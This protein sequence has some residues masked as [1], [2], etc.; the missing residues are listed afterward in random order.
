M[1]PEISP[2]TLFGPY[3]I[4][5]VLGVGGMGKVYRARDTRLHRTVAIKVLPHAKVA[6]DE[7]KR[8]F[9]QEA[10]AVS[11][12]NH[13]N[14]VTLH[15]MASEGGVDYLVMEYVPGSS[16]DRLITPKGLP[17]DQAVGY[18][19]QI[20]NAL[21]A[22]H[23]AGIVHRDMKPA[24]V[25]VTP[26]QAGGADHRYATESQVKV[27]DFGLAKL[28]G[29]A[30]G[31]EDETLT[32]ESEFTEAGK[33]MGTVAYMSPEQAR[34][35]QVDHRTDIFSLAVILY[36]MVAGTRPFRGESPVETMHGIINDPAPPL[37][38]QPPELDEILAKAMGKDPRHRYCHA[39]DFELDLRRF[40]SAWTLKELPSQRA[41]IPAAQ[42]STGRRLVV[43]AAVTL[44]AAAAGAAFSWWIKPD[45]P[46]RGPVLTSLP[47]D[48][49]LTTDPILSS[50]GRFVAYASD[51][52]GDGNLDIW[53]QQVAG[54]EPVRLTRDPADE[55]EPSFSPDGSKIAFRSERDGGGIYVISTLGGEPRRI[56]DGGRR[57]R[58]SPDGRQIA[59]WTGKN[60]NFQIFTP[61]S[62]KI[63]V[64]GSGGGDSREIQPG[65]LLARSPVWSA[66]GKYLLFLG[67]RDSKTLEVDWW[68][69]P[70]DSGQAVQT[71]AHALLTAYGLAPPDVFFIP[72]AWTKHGNGVLFAGA[73]GDSTN[74]WRIAIPPGGRAT[75]LP[76]RLTFGAGLESNPS[77]AA[78]GRLV[79]STLSNNIDLW[80]LPTDTFH[81][82]QTGSP[83]ERLTHDPAVDYYPA[84]SSDGKKLIY[85]STQSENTSLWLLDM[86]A[87]K[88]TVI[89]P[90]VGRWQN[91]V[92]TRDG[93]SI[94]FGELY[95]N[96][97]ANPWY[98]LLL[99]NGWAA[100]PGARQRL[101]DNCWPVWDLSADGRWLLHSQQGDKLIV[102]R[103]MASGRTTELLRGGERMTA[104]ARISP[105]NRWVIFDSSVRQLDDVFLIPFHPGMPPVETPWIALTAGEGQNAFPQWSLDSRLVYYFSDRDGRFCVWAQRIRPDTGH[106]DGEPFPVWHFHDARR[107]L[108]G[109]PYELMGMAIAPGRIVLS[110][111]EMSGNIW[112][113]QSG[114]K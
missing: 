55:S 24:N 36:E 44:C 71:G 104:K 42:P 15:D 77:V 31:P 51:R 64:I 90:R 8:R 19:A 78:D 6:D 79:F 65:F 82:K 68:T 67:C 40:A 84:L 73:L 48:A 112:M 70:L 49:G 74:I 95:Q 46:S 1:E 63:H 3:K 18:A 109:M 61:S 29:R 53:V 56:A 2:G 14:I 47:T 60:L 23:A 62:A 106:P 107:S 13:P 5:G 100:H 98:K 39:G 7:R 76:E 113:A 108:R 20:A 16:L 87:G 26:N 58:F 54:G 9:L 50:D 38:G 41:A 105:D 110:L 33:I 27:L 88:K 86:T 28:T 17:L 25:V 96:G 59:Y 99:L 102:A 45:R 32:Q 22:A 43:F 30:T 57:P 83:P 81:A 93:S 94:L 101:C 80:A 35:R 103:D 21:A 34:G 10:R 69:T 91:P 52:G 89:A 12:L 85:L 66:D 72:A 114:G 11:A 92:I 111:S 97:G 75:G 4:E 37:S